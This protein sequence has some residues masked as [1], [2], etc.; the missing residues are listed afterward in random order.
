MKKKT[1]NKN[2]ESLF[3]GSRID[4]LAETLP[5]DEL[6]GSLVREELR[7]AGC[8]V[9]CG[10]DGIVDREVCAVGRGKERAPRDAATLEAGGARCERLVLADGV[11]N[12]HACARVHRVGE[13]DAEH[14][15]ERRRECGVVHAVGRDDE[16]ARV[17]QA[18]AP[19]RLER[20]LLPVQACRAAKLSNSICCVVFKVLLFKTFF[21]IAATN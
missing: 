9:L 21:F 8:K 15:G 14:G 6:C 20:V 16:V 12:E 5:D 4:V 3:K 1:K 13:Q 7:Y 11:G 2:V 18:L 17:R 10:R 19:T